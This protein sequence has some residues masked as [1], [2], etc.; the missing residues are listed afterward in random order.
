[1]NQRDKETIIEEN[2]GDKKTMQGTIMTI[3]E[4]IKV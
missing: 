1:M 3:T 2:R 4:K